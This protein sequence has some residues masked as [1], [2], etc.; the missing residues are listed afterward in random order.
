MGLTIENYMIMGKVYISL[1]GTI[2][3]DDKSFCDANDEN[4][5]SFFCWWAKIYQVVNCL[6]KSGRNYF[7]VGLFW[8]SHVTQIKFIF[9]R[10]SCEHYIYTNI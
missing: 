2:D 6:V 10:K 5:A 7:E 9:Q 1:M 8:V 4:S 3:S